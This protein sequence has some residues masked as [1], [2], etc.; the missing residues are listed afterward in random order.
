MISEE[1]FITFDIFNPYKNVVCVFST[2]IGGISKGI[3]SSQNLGN[4]QN[5]NPKHVE[6]NRLNFFN[7]IDV[8]PSQVAIPGQI[9][10]TNVEL[11]TSAG[12]KKNTD[13]LITN[14]VNLYLAIQTADCF[15]LFLYEPESQIIGII[16]AGWRGALNGIVGKTLNLM[17]NKFGSNPEKILVSVG[18]G[19]QKECFEIREDVFSR[20]PNSFCLTHPEPDKRYLDLQKYIKE[21]LVISGIRRQNIEINTN[22][23]KCLKQLYYSFRRDGGKS[24]RM[25]GILGIRN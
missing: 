8:D 24:G 10:S 14:Q 25:M 22:C 5:D 18:P 15:P 23:T 17:K 2:R 6:L 20:F 7:K 16:H 9:H 1:P 12:L 19:L 13:A 21:T 11:V 4:I 3:F